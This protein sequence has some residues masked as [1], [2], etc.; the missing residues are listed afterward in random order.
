M[1]Q[2]NSYPRAAGKR[3]PLVPLL[4]WQKRYLDDESRFKLVVASVQSGKSFATSLEFALRALRPKRSLGILLSASERQSVELMEKVK[5]HTAGWGVVVESGFFLETTIVQHTATFPNGNRII[6]LPANPDTARGYSGDVF[7]DEFALHRDAKAIWAAMMGRATRGYDVRVASTFKGTDNKFYD[8][9]KLLG[10]EEGTAPPSQPVQRGGWSGHWVDIFMCRAQGL[11]V[12]IEGLRQAID[13]E[14][15]FQQEYCNVPM[16]GAESFIPLELVLACES[17]E[18]TIEPQIDAGPRGYPRG[19]SSIGVHRRS[20]A[21]GFDVG[22]KKDRSVIWIVEQ[23]R[24]R[25][26][27]RGVITMDQTPFADQLKVARDVAA[28]V[29]RFAIDATG[30]GA[31]LAEELHRE[32]PWVEPVEFSSAV[33]ERLAVELKKRFE[34]HTILLPESH[35][36]RRACSA[37]KRYIGPTGGIRFDA[38]RSEAGHADEFWALALACSAASQARTYVP[39][40]EVGLVG[41]ATLAGLRARVF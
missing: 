2:Q 29:E 8:L 25:L 5:M 4:A 11:A 7:L 30:I 37:V 19:F 34:E 41:R 12:D 36:I 20:S 35:K 26:I 13:D 10:L 24:E 6:A 39:A 27:T 28:E 3:N 32:F 1:A 17:P 18:A 40:A 38:A 21:A 31:M 23:D 16:S 14:A 15:I 22:R 9:A 33:K